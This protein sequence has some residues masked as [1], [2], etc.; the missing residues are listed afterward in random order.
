MPSDDVDHSVIALEHTENILLK[1]PALR[2]R[3][4]SRSSPEAAAQNGVLPSP[5]SSRKRTNDEAW[6][7]AGSFRSSPSPAKLS[8]RPS[9][10]PEQLKLQTSVSANP[11]SHFESE[12]LTAKEPVQHEG[13]T[14]G[15]G[16][17]PDSIHFKGSQLQQTFVHRIEKHKTQLESEF[18]DYEHNLHVAE[19]G[20]PLED[21]DWDDL[22]ARYNEAINSI[23][24]EE[25][26]LFE[27]FSQL[28]AVRCFDVA[29]VLC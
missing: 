26:E 18:R 9:T 1:S 2:D 8:I 11:L 19:K 29:Q 12:K 5:R 4:S 21:L 6:D 17:Q 14:D 15:E 20:E 13:R 24:Q 16:L 27:K 3:R 23:T 10:A 28:F 25:D 7:D 22:E